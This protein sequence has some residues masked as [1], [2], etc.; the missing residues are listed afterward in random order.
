[1]NPPKSMTISIAKDPKV[2]ETIIFR[3]RAAITWKRA[4]DIWCKYERIETIEETCIH[5]KMSRSQI[6]NQC[7]ENL[8]ILSNL[9]PKDTSLP[10]NLW[11]KTHHIVS[12]YHPYSKLHK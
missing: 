3:P 12:Y 7:Q 1:M 11:I 4:N 6:S 8:Q 10:C 5:V 9:L 2:L